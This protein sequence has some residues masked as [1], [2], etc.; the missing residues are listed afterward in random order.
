[1]SDRLAR[2]ANQFTLVISEEAMECSFVFCCYALTVLFYL[3]F[4][5]TY[6]VVKT[7][8]VISHLYLKLTLAVVPFDEEPILFLMNCDAFHADLI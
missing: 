4:S 1:M 2:S 3:L 6:Q 8:D 5:T 7:G